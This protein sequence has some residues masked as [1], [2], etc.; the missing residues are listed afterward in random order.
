MR[1]IPSFPSFGAPFFRQIE[2]KHSTGNQPFVMTQNSNGIPSDLATKILLLKVQQSIKGSEKLNCFLVFLTAGCKQ[3]AKSAISRRSV[4]TQGCFQWIKKV[5]ILWLKCMLHQTFRSSSPLMCFQGSFCLC[6]RS[7][8]AKWLT[9]SWIWAKDSSLHAWLG[10]TSNSTEHSNKNI[11]P[12]ST[13]GF[14]KPL[15]TLKCVVFCY[16]ILY[17]FTIHHQLTFALSRGILWIFFSCLLLHL[18]LE[19]STNNTGVPEA[20]QMLRFVALPWESYIKWNTATNCCK[21]Q[22][23]GSMNY[24]WKQLCN[25]FMHALQNIHFLSLLHPYIF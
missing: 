21:Q 16:L 17:S 10:T 24:H 22:Y 23:R 7:R 8:S 11:I 1:K 14:S 13:T 6:F 3:R 2:T 15:L 19:V 25:G 4:F 12:P 20:Q 9:T 18:T 5:K